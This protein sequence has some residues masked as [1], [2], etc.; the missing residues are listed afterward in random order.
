M[1]GQHSGKRSVR[2]CAVWLGLTGMVFLS[3][4]TTAPP[5]NAAEELCRYQWIPKTAEGSLTFSEDTLSLS[6]Q[7]GDNSVKLSGVYFADDDT[8]TV[9]SEDYGTVVMQYALVAD[10][11]RLT[12]FDKE[13]VFV[14]EGGFTDTNA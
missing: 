12:Y 8:L 3:G 6:V 9:L 10:Q 7:Q 1:F 14:K 2:R 4:C 5:Q 11:L 13:A